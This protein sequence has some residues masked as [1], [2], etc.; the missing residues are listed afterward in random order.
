MLKLSGEYTATLDD[1]TRVVLPSAL[2]KELGSLADKPLFIQKNLYKPCIDIFA[3]PQWDERVIE[4][5]QTLDKFDDD[6]DNFLQYFST[7]HVQA[8]LAPNGRITIPQSFKQY[9]KL[10][11]NIVF[12][13]MTNFIRLWDAD[14]YERTK[15]DQQTFI[16]KFKEKRKKS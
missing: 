7:T 5:T 14:E 1:K 6:D 15:M 16:Q 2:K 12:I 8:E 10:S 11:K 3:E 9:A 4:F 13:G